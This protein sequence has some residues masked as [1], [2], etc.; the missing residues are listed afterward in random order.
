MSMEPAE[1][2]VSE[3]SS[4]P[5]DSLELTD[6]RDPER[7]FLAKIVPPSVAA[8]NGTVLT[9]RLWTSANNFS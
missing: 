1:S 7:H 9:K 3:E 2:P 4:E 5:K 8:L 6:V